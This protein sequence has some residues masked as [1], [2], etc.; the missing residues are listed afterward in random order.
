MSKA[1]LFDAD[2][3]TIVGRYKYFSDRLSAEYDIPVEKIMHFF[4]NEYQLCSLGKADLRE[5]VV[6]YF[7]SWNWTGGVDTLLNYWFSGENEINEAV[8]SYADRLRSKGIRCYLVTDQEKYRARY[9]WDTMRFSEHFDGSFFSCNLGF[10]KSDREFFQTVL[11]KISPILA[12][13]TE[14]WD[15][16]AKNVDVAVQLGI[17]GKVFTTTDAFSSEMDRVYTL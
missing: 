14:Y 4:K 7:E 9:I 15:D 12:E 1:V 3:V 10:K 11:D 13:E 17:T 6:K 8:L 5:E 2:G 16:D